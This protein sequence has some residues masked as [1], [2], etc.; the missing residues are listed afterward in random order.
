MSVNKTIILG[1]LGNDP[2]MKNLPNGT[3]VTNLSVATTERWMKDG[4]KQEKTEWHRCV[5]YGKQAEIL[6]NHLSKGREIYIEGKLQT[7]SW[8]DNSGAKRYSTEIIGNSFSFIG[9]NADKNDALKDAH[10]KKE[11]YQVN[12]NTDFASDSIPF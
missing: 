10:S 4:Q 9:G 11:E 12:T 6:N 2:E 3:V 5:F 8:E 7:R 1:R